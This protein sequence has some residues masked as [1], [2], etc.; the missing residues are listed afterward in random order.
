MLFN[1]RRLAWLVA[2][3]IYV[4]RLCSRPGFDSRVPL[5][6]VTPPLLLCFL[7]HS[8]TILSIK[9]EKGQKNNIKKK[10]MLFNCHVFCLCVRWYRIFV[11]V[12]LN[13][14]KSAEV[15]I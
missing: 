4:P 13:H 9:P 1:G 15:H 12:N 5:L 14:R 11:P 6:R 7:S 8:S 3:A 2:R 10:K